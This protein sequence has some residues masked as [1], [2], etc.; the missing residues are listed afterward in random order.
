MNV[1]ILNRIKSYET[2]LWLFII[3]HVLS[4]TKQEM[5]TWIFRKVKNKGLESR[6]KVSFEYELG[7]KLV[8]L[9]WNIWLCEVEK[10]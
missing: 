7:E 8:I 1:K 5:G 6:E 10:L 4:P 3:V 9:W 2:M